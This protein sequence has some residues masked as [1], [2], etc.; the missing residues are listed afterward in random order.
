MRRALLL[1]LFF[2]ALSDSVCLSLTVKITWAID[3]RV[4]TGSFSREAMT[5]S[6]LRQRTASFCRKAFFRCKT[7]RSICSC[8]L[9]HIRESIDLFKAEPILYAVSIDGC[10]SVFFPFVIVEYG[11]SAREA[12]I[13]KLISR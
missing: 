1:S 3:S 12:S 13:F 8:V 9:S 10:R 11:T 7:A 4:P 6:Y 5:L 2:A